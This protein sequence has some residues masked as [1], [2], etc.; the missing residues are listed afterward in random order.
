MYNCACQ[1][2]HAICLYKFYGLS[3]LQSWSFHISFL[4]SG[5]SIWSLA[6]KFCDKLHC[7]RVSSPFVRTGALSIILF[8]QA[9]PLICLKGAFTSNVKF[10]STFSK[11]YLYYGSSYKKSCKSRNTVMIQ[12]TVSVHTAYS[13]TLRFN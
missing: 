7:F 3:Y 1:Y 13:N 2:W 8:V 5:S 9:F 6:Q 12:G 10:W 4:R 11:I